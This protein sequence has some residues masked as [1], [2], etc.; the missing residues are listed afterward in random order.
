VGSVER[1]TRFI[2]ECGRVASR[3]VFLTTPNRWFPVEFHTVLP[4]VHWLPKQAFRG[5]MRRAGREFF[6]AEENLN[7]MTSTSDVRH[8]SP[9][10]PRAFP[11]I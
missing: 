2:A 7:L 5:L 9:S 11:C 3:A 4:L 6:A 8:R 10:R 1:Q